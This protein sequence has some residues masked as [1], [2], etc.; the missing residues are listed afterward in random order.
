MARRIPPTPPK[1]DNPG[2]GRPKVHSE[3]W[4]KV[5][6]ILFTRQVTHLD[7]IAQRARR[8]GHRA[9]TRATVIRGV[10]DGVL[11]S[12]LD[13]SRHPS[14]MHLREEITNRL[15]RQPR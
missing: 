3:P 13:I 7:R 12:D 5:S 9:M 15:K 2:P 10:I 11:K 1:D 14:E 4:S 8:R 6:V